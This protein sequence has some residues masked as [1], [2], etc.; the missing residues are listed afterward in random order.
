MALLSEIEAR[1]T[2]AETTG[3]PRA[4][5][6]RSP[7]LTSVSNMPIMEVS[8]TCPAWT[9]DSLGGWGTRGD[10]REWQNPTAGP[11]G[12]DEDDDETLLHAGKGTLL[13]TF[14]RVSTNATTASLCTQPPNPAWLC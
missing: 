12:H 7:V 14:P 3:K 6:D 9:Q 13:Q 8:Y 11:H 2:T 10:P 5:A 4:S 1:M